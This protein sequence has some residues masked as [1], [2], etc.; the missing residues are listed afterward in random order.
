MARP[1]SAASVLRNMKKQTFEP[2]TPIASEMFIPNHSGI[3]DHPE[4]KGTFVLK[5]GDTMTGNLIVNGSIAITGDNDFNNEYL[6]AGRWIGFNA[7]Q[8]SHVDFKDSSTGYAFVQGQAGNVLISSHTG[9]TVTINIANSAAITVA[10]TKDVTMS[11]SLTVG[12]DGQSTISKGMIINS[13]KGTDSLHD[14]RV[15]GD[16]VDDLIH[17]DSSANG[18]GFYNATPV[19]KQTGVAVS[20]AG[21]HTALVNLG[22]ISA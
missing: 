7:A 3:A 15:H 8:F 13:D 4:A 9:Q 16:T 12:G 19:A 10:T 21:I 14:L 17:T 18:L 22:L 2:K 1:P 11:E 6:Y 5:A 20:A